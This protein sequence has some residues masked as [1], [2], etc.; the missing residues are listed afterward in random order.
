MNPNF[1]SYF[2]TYLGADLQNVKAGEIVVARSTRRMQPEYGWGYTV[3]AWLF[4]YG[5]ATMISA[6]PAL[7]EAVSKAL[8]AHH[9]AH[10]VDAV[11]QAL[12]PAIANNGTRHHF[13]YTA[14]DDSVQRITSP[15][16]RCLTMQDIDAFI[17]MS[18][19]MYPEIDEECERN[20][21]TR[22][23]EDGIAFGAF[24]DGR[25]V[26]RCY[27]PHIAHM[28]DRVEEIGIDTLETY[29]NRGFASAA[30]A[31]STL[32]TLAIGRLP[33][34]RVSIYNTPSIRIVERVGYRRVAESVEWIAQ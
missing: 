24:V 14:S 21:I 18:R 1:A 13:I 6:Q 31:G 3:A 32:A 17:D 23:I 26:T 12:M 27:A 5:D 22:N 10:N 2:S 29:R 28:Q 16:V 25:M 15:Q 7:V 8:D 34:Y 11:M 4:C 33:I 9:D 19:A 20:D 30:L